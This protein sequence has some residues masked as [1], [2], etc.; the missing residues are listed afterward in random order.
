[1]RTQDRCIAISL[2]ALLAAAGCGDDDPPGSTYYERNIE[3]I[4]IQFCAGNVAGCHVANDDDPFQFAA[5]NLDVSSFERLQKRRDLMR[6][7]GPYSV[8]VMLIKAVGETDE[9][10]FNYNGE[11]RPLKVQHAGG[12]VFQVGSDAYLTLLTWME[13]GATENGLP[14]PA[15]PRTGDGPCSTAIPTGFDPAEYTANAEFA[16]FRDDVQPLLNDCN[17]GNCHGTPQADFYITCGDDDD[18]LA[19]NFSQVWSFVDDPVDN[20]QVLQVPLAVQA[21]GYFHTGGEHFASRDSDEY[22][23]IKE[24]AT[25]VGKVDFAGGDAG[26]AFFED[27]VQPVLVERGCSFEACHSPQAT[28]DFKMRS[29]SQG[30]FSAIALERNYE[31]LKKEFLAFEM[32]DV[33]RGRAVAKSILPVFGGI[34]HRGGPVLETPG[35]G[36]AQPGTCPTPYDPATASAYC[37]FQEWLD[38]ERAALIADGTVLPLG[39][40]DTVPLV[41]VDRAEDHVAGPLEFD[42]YQADS[43][44]M[45]ATAT[46]AADGSISAGAPASLLDNCAGASNRAVVDVRGPDVSF[47]GERVAFAMRTSADEPLSIYIVGIDGAGCTRVT[48]PQPDQ[49]GIKIHNFDPAWAPDDQ[50]LVFASTRGATG[51][52]PSLSRRLFL[53]QADIWRMRVDGSDPEPMTF[54]TNS[55][56]N[57][58]WKRIGQVTMTTEK[59]SEGFYQLAGRRI[60]WDLTDYHPLLAQRAESPFAD[61]ADP[62]AMAPSVGYQQ[63]TDVRES[64]NGDFL[65]ILSDAG[66]RGGAGTLAIFNRSVGPF[67]LGR[68]DPGFLKSVTIPDPAATGRVGS[69]STGAYRSPFPLLDGRIMASYAEGF[70]GDLGTATSFNWDIVAVNPRTGEREAIIGGPGAQVEAVLALKYPERDFFLNKRQLVFGGARD[71]QLA[72]DN[73]AWVHLPDAPVVMT[74][75][76]ANLRRGRPFDL[77]SGARYIAAW[78]EAGAPAGSTANTGDIY[79]NRTYLGRAP[80]A[81]DGSVRFRAPAGT[82]LLLELQDGDGNVLFRMTEEHQLG[83]GEVISLGIAGELFD[84]VCGGCHGSVSGS[85]LDVAVTPDALT[86]ASESLSADSDP[87]TLSP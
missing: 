39:T 67:E 31:L 1:M 10:G 87:V 66:A 34:A 36:G 29:G 11:F 38:V 60:N 63:A 80:L 78:T 25:A 72:A 61:P 12:P 56:V 76:D 27:H 17:S 13:N 28:N 47:D 82:P 64:S 54:L 42:T 49:N 62:T 19:F 14:P 77:Y 9:L 40:G 30:F 59:V 86:G 85:E 65:L 43:D 48:P 71:E 75:F 74:L 2:F 6:P 21:G 33:R 16:R 53:P 50:W 51:N 35:S 8:P 46:V 15:P 5:G 22:R 20:S 32:P 18:Q 68:D 3:P 83:P 58:Q 26:K 52:G 70:T 24:W 84:A 45:I 69:S 81:S 57:P 73:E 7:F 79:Q 37:T 41:Y 4:L 23:V 44:L 55:E